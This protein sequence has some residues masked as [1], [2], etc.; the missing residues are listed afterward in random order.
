MLAS[1]LQEIQFI[2]LFSYINFSNAHLI[3]FTYNGN[4]LSLWYF[5]GGYCQLQSLTVT[6]S[7]Q[8]PSIYSPF[9]VDRYHP[10]YTPLVWLIFYVQWHWEPS[11]QAVRLLLL[12][13]CPEPELN[14]SLRWKPFNTFTS[15]KRVPRSYCSWWETTMFIGGNGEEN[16]G[17][18]SRAHLQANKFS[19][20]PSFFVKQ[21]MVQA[22]TASRAKV[23]LKL[24]RRNCSA[25]LKTLQI[26]V[27]SVLHNNFKT[28]AHHI[29]KFGPIM[30]Q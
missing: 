27:S 1:L 18:G 23:S 9:W 11:H 8:Q 5:M 15:E 6:F 26:S 12:P 4:F 13:L 2:R 20:F 19:N 3:T 29:I 16:N 10:Y 14:C 30:I 17:A 21:A 24:S 25:W 28:S 22:F 7:W